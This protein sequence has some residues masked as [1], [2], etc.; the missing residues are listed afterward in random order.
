MWQVF[1]MNLAEYGYTEEEYSVEGL[2]NIYTWP[3]DAGHAR[4]AM[5]NAPYGSRILVRK[6]ADPACFSGTVF[7][8]M[9]NWARGYD[10]TICSWGNCHEQIMQKGDAWI[11]VTI[12][13]SV[14]DNLKKF[15]PARYGRLS[16][17]NPVPR[18]HRV[19]RPQSN[20][21]HD[22]YTDP[23][24]ENGLTWDFYSQTAILVREQDPRNPLDGYGVRTVIGT[25]AT[26][27]DLATYAAA[28]DPVVCASDGSNIFDGFLIFMTGAPGNVNQYEEKLH[29]MDPRCR[30][31][32][33]VPLI[34]A[35]TCKDM[36][37]GGFH[38]DWAY[39]QR[40]NDSDGDEAGNYYRSYEI[41]GTSLFLSYTYHLEPCHED[42]AKMG[43]VIK[44][45]RTGKKWTEE[46][47]KAFEFPTRYALDAMH[48]NLKL[49]IAEGIAPP[50][51][52][53]Y[54]TEHAYPATEL[55]EDEYGN[56]LGGL[57][58]PY[59]RVPAYHLRKD[60]KAE[61][62]GQELLIRLYK[63]AG[64]Y[65][66]KVAQACEDCVRERIL[67]RRDADKIIREA[68][69]TDLFR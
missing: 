42:V 35:Y 36:L 58:L 47:L 59:L 56:V 52:K 5:Q 41:A 63:D 28:I 17:E 18:E 20:T 2:A 16:F 26:A 8:E 69:E 48:E 38:P 51:C 27:G 10:R 21:Y 19:D 11:G 9:L 31:Y 29:Y 13:S 32:G 67:T 66:A 30:F 62:F 34:R 37:G 12:R 1:P 53:P 64:S 6:P 14:I 60:A 4:V 45:Y 50:C 65:A 54:E 61:A 40:R 3:E 57:R 33:K 68:R 25:G 24:R 46:D 39:M 44:N 23:D 15:D 22:D 7:I 55:A 43:L 49:W